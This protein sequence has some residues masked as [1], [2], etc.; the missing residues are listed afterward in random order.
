MLSR[1]IASMNPFPRQTLNNKFIDGW[2]LEEPDST[3][4]GREVMR[5]DPTV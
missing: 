4:K 1:Q 3:K 2:E 5:S